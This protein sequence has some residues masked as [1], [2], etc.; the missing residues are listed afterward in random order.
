MK[1]GLVGRVHAWDW[2]YGRGWDSANNRYLPAVTPF[3]ARESPHVYANKIANLIH[4]GSYSTWSELT[5][6][7]PMLGFLP[8]EKAKSLFDIL[9]AKY[10]AKVEF[11][12]YVPVQVSRP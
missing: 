1:Y 11:D 3:G 12:G 10:K 9:K 4:P 7:E 8:P 2:S 5:D 6:H